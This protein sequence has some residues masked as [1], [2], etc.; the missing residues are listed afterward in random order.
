[1]PIEHW[2]DHPHRLVMAK[3]RGVFTDQDVFGYQRE[4]WSQPEVAGYSELMDM[5][6]VEQIAIVSAER[7]RQLA[8]LAAEMDPRS[9]QS[10]LAIVAPQELAFGL[11]RMFKAFRNSEE[12]GTKEVGVFRTLPEAYVFL[13]IL[14][15]PKKSADADVPTNS[16]PP[17]PK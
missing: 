14:H 16:N 3:G 13:G 15:E 10:R 4:V 1:M 6:D 12:Q 17:S 8:R 5:T 9:A 7:I 11:G 2:I